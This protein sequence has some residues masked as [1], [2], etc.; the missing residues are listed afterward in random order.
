MKQKLTPVLMK[1]TSS[2]HDGRGLL[3]APVQVICRGHLRATPSGFLLRYEEHQEEDGSMQD[4]ILGLSQNRVTMTRMGDYSTTMV[5]E[6]GKRFEGAYHT[7]FGDLGLALF[8]T[9]VRCHLTPEQGTAHLEY[10]LDMQGN[11]AAMQT[12]D[13]AYT[14]G[15]QG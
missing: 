1:L 6:K 7:P 3:D 14:A 4:V 12:I 15:E 11:Y 5:F 10:Q 13:I 9:C 8:T 2:A